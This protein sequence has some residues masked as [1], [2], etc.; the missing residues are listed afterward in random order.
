[1]DIYNDDYN[2]LNNNFICMVNSEN[3]FPIIN[4]QMQGGVKRHMINGIMKSKYIMITTNQLQILDA[5]L[6]DGGTKKYID[7][8]KKLRYSE[9]SGLFDLKKGSVDKI[10]ISA[11]TNR[12]DKDDNDILLPQSHVEQLKYEYIFHTHPA[13][14]YAGARAISGIIYEWPS[15]SDL[16]HFIYHYNEGEVLGSIIVAPEGIYMIQANK[17]VKYIDYPANNFFK[18]MENIQTTIQN[19]AIQK[20]G[21]DY[22][23]HRQK[24]YYETVIQDETYINKYKKMV[25]KYFNNNI[26]IKY[27][28][29]QYN[30]QMGKWIID[31]LYIKQ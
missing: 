1:M 29:R 28:A 5:L 13:T 18:K 21:I 26:I 11:K 16:Y 7:K 3:T 4:Y 20:Y 23:N 24:I 6:Y 2:K 8:K 19:E 12:E 14:P 25:K 27:K 17:D 15:I 9:H 22:S 10:I 31:K 30:K